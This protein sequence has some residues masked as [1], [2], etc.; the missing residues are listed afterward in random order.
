MAR[1]NS[2]DSE[3]DKLLDASTARIGNAPTNF[4]SVDDFENAENET[5]STD[6]EGT[7]R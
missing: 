5:A 4:N 3:L 1:D 6:N 7:E 2:Q